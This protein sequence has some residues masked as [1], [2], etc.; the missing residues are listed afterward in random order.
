[1]K[2]IFLIAVSIL[3]IVSVIVISTGLVIYS[4]K[5][6]IIETNQYIVKVQQF[7][8]EKG[9]ASSLKIIPAGSIPVNDITKNKYIYCVDSS[10][11]VHQF[12]S[13]I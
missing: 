12:L 11:E 6:S 3:I 13:T 1:M 5:S 8:I 4:I 10:N 2:N 9:M 7:C